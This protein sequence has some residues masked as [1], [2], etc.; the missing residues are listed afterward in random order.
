VFADRYTFSSRVGLILE[1]L[2]HAAQALFAPLQQCAEHGLVAFDANNQILLSTEHVLVGTALLVA[3]LATIVFTRRHKPDVAVGCAMVLLA[4]GPTSNL[5]PTHFQCIF[6]E[7]FLYLPTLGVAF[8]VT[9]V[10]S[11]VARTRIRIRVGVIAAMILLATACV[12]SVVRTDDYSATERFWTHELRVNPLSTTAHQNLVDVARANRDVTGAVQHLSECHHNAV[13]RRQHRT[14]LRCAYDG[15]VIIADSTPDLDKAALR[16]TQEFFTAFAPPHRERTAQLALGSVT[17]TIDNRQTSSATMA[18]ELSG[19]SLA[20]LASIALKLDDPSAVEAARLALRSCPRCRY[21]LRAARVLAARGHIGEGLAALN[22][23]ER[24]GS[25]LSVSRVRAQIQAFDSWMR[26]AKGAVGP[27]Q[28]QATAQAYL[29]LG[30]Y[31]AAYNTLRPYASEITSNSAAS[32]QYA[33]VAY[34]AGDA[35][36]ARATLAMTLQPQAIDTTLSD[37]KKG[38]APLHD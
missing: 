27:A 2:G 14:A 24:E 1:T 9:S 26:Q 15:A 32:L 28:V 4:L 10:L 12:R 37:W 5:I 19:E 8:L 30:L 21:A 33:E 23:L 3:L 35:P 29:A 11:I 25:L 38:S 31:G 13:V 17:V 20:M 22:E 16:A 6:Y 36:A 34:Y 7:R 18:R